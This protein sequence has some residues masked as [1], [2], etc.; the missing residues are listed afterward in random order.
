MAEIIKY[1]YNPAN[2]SEYTGDDYSAVVT[3]DFTIQEFPYDRVQLF[4]QQQEYPKYNR[5]F[6]NPYPNP[7]T[8]AILIV[9]ILVVSA[10][11]YRRAK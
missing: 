5:I 9:L 4:I 1:D 10:L 11:I 6:P 2:N 7:F 3:W 8:I